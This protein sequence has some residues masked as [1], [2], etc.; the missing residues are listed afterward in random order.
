[1]VMQDTIDSESW[2]GWPPIHGTKQKGV[3]FEHFFGSAAVGETVSPDRCTEPRRS[4]TR[5]GKRLLRHA[6]ALALVAAELDVVP[7]FRKG[8][9][10][11]RAQN[12]INLLM[13]NA[14]SRRL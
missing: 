4:Q 1:M 7:R 8:L 6:C 3:N 13:D 14:F 12:S 11:P 10:K 2:K 9:L 5:L